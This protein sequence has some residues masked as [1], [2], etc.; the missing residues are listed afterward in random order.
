MVNGTI[1]NLLPHPFLNDVLSLPPHFLNL[2]LIRNHYSH[3]SYLPSKLYVFDKILVFIRITETN[4]FTFPNSSLYHP[5]TL[6][7]GQDSTRQKIIYE[8]LTF[9]N[10]SNRLDGV[11]VLHT[12]NGTYWVIW[13]KIFWTPNVNIVEAALL[14]SIHIFSW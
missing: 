8:I 5:S 12:P 13:T 7:Y 3:T 11:L 2:Q 4:I 6:S 9:Y 1:R 14:S 10:S